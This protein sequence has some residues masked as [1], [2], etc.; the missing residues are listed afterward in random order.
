MCRYIIPKLKRQCRKKSKTD[1]CWLHQENKVRKKEM[2]EKK[3]CHYILPKQKR[4]CRNKTKS[5]TD[6]CWLHQ[7]NKAPAKKNKKK[8]KKREEETQC[9]ICL[10]EFQ[11]EDTLKVCRQCQHRFH[12][13]CIVNSGKARCPLC[14][15]DMRIP[16][17]YRK[18][19]EEKN[20][21]LREYI[22]PPPPRHAESSVFIPTDEDNRPTGAV[23]VHTPEDVFFTFDEIL[24]QQ[25]H[26]C[27]D[28]VRDTFERLGIHSQDYSCF[29]RLSSLPT[30][31][32]SEV[33]MME[34]AL[35]IT[36]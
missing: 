36:Q 21:E 6:Y 13:S 35:S 22:N 30:N 8:K 19:L 11:K 15:K 1:Y 29:T 7:E 14:L 25:E 4:K 3:T 27:P 5:E 10:F 24:N 31:G 32:R 26:L 17:K 18:K 28:V 20:R 2:K 33:E 9:I 23:V 34:Y 12:M 16:K